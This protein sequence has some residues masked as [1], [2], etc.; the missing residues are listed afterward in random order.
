MSK[1]VIFLPSDGP[2]RRFPG[3]IQ[4]LHS[5]VAAHGPLEH[6][7]LPHVR[8]DEANVLSEGLHQD[9]LLVIR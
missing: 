3:P 5:D 6:H 9:W 7:I 4:G 8:A 1:T 2:Q